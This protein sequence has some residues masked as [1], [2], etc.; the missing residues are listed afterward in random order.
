MRPV[1]LHWLESM[2]GGSRLDNWGRGI[3]VAQKRKKRKKFKL[4]ILLEVIEREYLILG[5]PKGN[6][7]REWG[8]GTVGV[9]WFPTLCRE[10]G[11]Q[12][13]IRLHGHSGE[14]NQKQE[15]P[16]HHSDSFL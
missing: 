5:G 13:R 7:A 10:A 16:R 1:L 2:T 15:S 3:S 8:T 12:S 6:R 9:W 14:K 11:G 4:G